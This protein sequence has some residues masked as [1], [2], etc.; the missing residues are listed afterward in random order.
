[1]KKATNL[2]LRETLEAGRH[3]VAVPNNDHGSVFCGTSR[4][5]WPQDAPRLVVAIHHVDKKCVLVLF[6]RPG[7]AP[8]DT[9]RVATVRINSLRLLAKTAVTD[10]PAPCSR[11]EERALREELERI[12]QKAAEAGER[13]G[14]L[15]R[16]LPFESPVQVAVA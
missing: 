11:E 16:I 4:I 13:L 12:H 1:M 5:P 14:P 3:A 9:R 2:N 15:A 7:Y 8:T 10:V 6:P